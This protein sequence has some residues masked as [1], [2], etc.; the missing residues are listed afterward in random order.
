VS[1]RFTTE[2][3]SVR[4]LLGHE[5]NQLRGALESR[6][7]VVDRL[8]V[9]VQQSGPAAYAGTSQQQADSG[10]GGDG[11]SRGQ[12]TNQSFTPQSGSN[13][14]EQRDQGQRPASFQE[15]LL[16]MVA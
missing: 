14:D 11:R 5:M 7:L 4:S 13:A 8:E 1:A 16:N 12:F 2:H 10:A 6:G 3:E 15:Q 9:Q